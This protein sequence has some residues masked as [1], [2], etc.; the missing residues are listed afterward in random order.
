[1]V[2]CL[3]KSIMLT[4]QSKIHLQNFTKILNANLLKLKWKRKSSYVSISYVLCSR[5]AFWI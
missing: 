5:T 1:M 2:V 4:R 3:N